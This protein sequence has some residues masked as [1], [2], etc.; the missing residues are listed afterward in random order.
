MGPGPP[1]PDSSSEVAGPSASSKGSPSVVLRK[2]LPDGFPVLPGAVAV[3]LPE[4]D[5]GLIGLWVSE[6]VGSA[7]YDFYAA[8]LPEAGYS[9]VGLYPGGEVALVRFSVPDGEIWQIMAHGTPDGR[10]AIEVRLD[11]P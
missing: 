6:A 10:L 2:P 7:A 3:P 11:R 1:S 4:D 5:P 8:A 9:I